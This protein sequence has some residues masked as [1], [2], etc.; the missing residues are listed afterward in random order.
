[1]VILC[2][3]LALYQRPESTTLLIGWYKGR[4][5][6]PLK[7]TPSPQGTGNVRD[8][9]SRAGHSGES[10]A[11]RERRPR[12]S[13]APRAHWREAQNGQK[14]VNFFCRWYNALILLTSF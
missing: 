13:R 10:R 2:R 3:W 12:R 7:R 6:G 14:S 1:M 11:R 4:D 9:K 8:E 5:C